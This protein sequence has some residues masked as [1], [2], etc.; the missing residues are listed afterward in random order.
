MPGALL[1]AARD[2]NQ[3]RE[4]GLDLLRIYLGIGLFARGALF[5][6][7]PEALLGYISASGDWFWPAALAHYVAAAHIFGGI[8]LALGAYTRLA[9][10]M[11][12]PVLAGAVF[13]THWGEGLL[14]KGQSLEFAGLVFFMLVV[15]SV[16]GAG[17]LSVDARLRRMKVTEDDKP[18]GDR[19]VPWSGY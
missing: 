17:P 8:L 7:E 13:V 15:F 5:V 1:R 3:S 4:L 6:A 12:V 2:L 10:V 19:Y 11:Q 18:L 14:S 9:A 16:F